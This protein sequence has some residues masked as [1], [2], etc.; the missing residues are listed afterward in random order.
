[1]LL[2]TLAFMQMG[3]FSCLLLPVVW[4]P[5]PW[6]FEV[7]WPLFGAALLG[8]G[9]QLIFFVTL[10][11]ATPSQL[12]PLLALKIFILAFAS[13]LFL[14][15]EISVLQWISIFFCFAATFLLNFSGRPIPL[16][17]FLGILVT[18]CCYALADVC[19]TMLIR[20]LDALGADHSALLAVCLVYALSGM[21][22]LILGGFMWSDLKRVSPW[23]F[24]LFFSVSF[25]IADVCLFAAFKLVGPVFANILQSLRGIISILLAKFIA[26]RGMHY[27]EHETDSSILLRRLLAAGLFSLAIALYV[28]GV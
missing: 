19:A 16:K 27:L 5:F 6:S 22:G 23:K 4:S 3:M 2:L 18:C 25:F 10:K 8:M 17:G 1:L 24:A 7:L 9:G 11:T 26:Q 12:T 14:H 28:L 21:L 13:I 20:R 15:K